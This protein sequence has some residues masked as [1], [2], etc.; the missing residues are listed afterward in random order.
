MEQREREHGATQTS[1]VPAG[2]SPNGADLHL[3][4]TEHLGKAC[5][6]HPLGLCW[7][8]CSQ[9]EQGYQTYGM[10]KDQAFGA[11]DV[12]LAPGCFQTLF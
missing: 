1:T 5:L 6:P 12:C 3:P 4:D 2:I 11:W 10:S 9:R 8:I 7:E